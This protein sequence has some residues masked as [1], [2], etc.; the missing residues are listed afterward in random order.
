MPKAIN[1]EISGTLPPLDCQGIPSLIFIC[2][3]RRDYPLP[4]RKC[5]AEPL[6]PVKLIDG[7][8]APTIFQAN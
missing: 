6:F 1:F 3:L 4:F 8:F 2:N 7:V 5:H